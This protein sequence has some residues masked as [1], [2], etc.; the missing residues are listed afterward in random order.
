MTHLEKLKLLEDGHPATY[1]N[2]KVIYVKDFKHP[3]DT[4]TIVIVT[5][6][7]VAIYTYM[8]TISELEEVHLVAFGTKLQKR[9]IIDGVVEGDAL[10]DEDGS[11]AV[12]LGVAG[13][14][15]FLSE[16]DDRTKASMIWTLEEIVNAGFKFCETPS[17]RIVE[18]TVQDISAGKGVGID[19]SLI[20]IKE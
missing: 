17:T 20:R 9:A 14:A 1:Y 3:V 18:L 2:E 5:E 7:P 16:P 19:P 6:D 10:L 13:K 15:I 11:I 8:L 12:V 4:E